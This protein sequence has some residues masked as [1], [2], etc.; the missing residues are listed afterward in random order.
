M[1]LVDIYLSGR[2]YS[3]SCEGGQ[4]ARLRQ[5]GEHVG[6]RLREL[7]ESGVTGSDA[8]MLALAALLVADELFDLKEGIDKS[9]SRGTKDPERE[10]AVAAIDTV[11]RRIEDLATR[12]ERP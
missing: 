12:L 4:E 7:A 10:Q 9:H 8:H 5:L 1:P 2:K 6:V 3:V 11:T